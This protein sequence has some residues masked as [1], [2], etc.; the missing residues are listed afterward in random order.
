MA[1]KTLIDNHR[2]MRRKLWNKA[3]LLCVVAFAISPEVKAQDPHFSQYY[4]NPLY[5]NP[6]FAGVGRC[7]KVHLNYR[8][9]FPVFNVYQT[10]SASYDQYVDNINGGLGFLAMRDMAG[11]GALNLTEFSGIYSY[12]LTVT[13]KFSVLA[14]FQATVR[15][16]SINWDNLTFPDQID[17]LFGFVLETN[18]QRPPN[19]VNTHIDLSIGFIGYSENFYIGVA[20]HH[21][22]EPD[23]RFFSE[24]R[25]PFKGTVHAGANIPLGRERYVGEEKTSLIPNFVYQRQGEFEQFFGGV[26][27]NYSVLT[28]GLAYRHASINPDAVIVLLGFSPDDL[29]MRIGYS[30]DYTVNK[31]SMGA[32]GAHEI[33]VVYQ[34]P[35]P[36]RRKKTQTIKCPKF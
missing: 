29:P 26:S 31:V 14:G 25:L 18:E 13:R 36:E 20:G 23:E 10:F 7:P 22:T 27:F 12:H 9:Q 35:C 5:L 17:P 4:A 16:R 6:A 1:R 19:E 11:D 15:S 8:N 21:L 2:Q 3:I 30:F 28:G 24:S 32:G 34:F 33:S